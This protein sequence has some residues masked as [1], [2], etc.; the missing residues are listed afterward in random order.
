MQMC[1][2]ARLLWSSQVL[3]D[4]SSAHQK[5]LHPL[6]LFSVNLGNVVPWASQRT[7]TKDSE[8]GLCGVWQQST[9]M[10]RAG[11]GDGP[12]TLASHLCHLQAE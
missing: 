6:K 10:G 4:L 8:W 1:T 3:P 9:V 2:H 7:D 5:S 11:S 12:P